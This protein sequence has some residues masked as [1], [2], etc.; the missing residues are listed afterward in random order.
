MTRTKKFVLRNGFIFW[1]G[2]TYINRKRLYVLKVGGI[3]EQIMK[4]LHDDIL[5]GHMGIERTYIRICQR[6]YWEGMK[7][8]VGRH[9]SRCT[10]HLNKA[11]NTRSWPGKSGFGHGLGC[12]PGLNTPAL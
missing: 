1:N 5:S 10:C 2:D 4:H 7:V 8:D 9:V 6:Y 3:R 12:S 11:N